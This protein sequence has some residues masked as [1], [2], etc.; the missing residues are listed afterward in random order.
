MGGKDGVHRDF[1]VRREVDGRS[2]LMRSLW[3]K[4]MECNEKDRVRKHQKERETVA[5]RSE[6]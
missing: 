5:V 2:R 3:E 6:R 1:L 4:E